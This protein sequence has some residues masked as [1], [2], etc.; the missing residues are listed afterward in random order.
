MLELPRGTSLLPT[1]ADKV[2]RANEWLANVPTVLDASSMTRERSDERYKLWNDGNASS[3]LVTRTAYSTLQPRQREEGRAS[4]AMPPL[5]PLPVVVG[6][7]QRAWLQRSTKLLGRLWRSFLSILPLGEQ[8]RNSN[9]YYPRSH[10][11]LAVRVPHSDGCV[12]SRTLHAW[13]LLG[14][15]LRAFFHA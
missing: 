2:L 1:D 5:G 7:A 6:C 9:S 15:P 8:T 4:S 3:S 14:D 12:L 13:A 11:W 10:V